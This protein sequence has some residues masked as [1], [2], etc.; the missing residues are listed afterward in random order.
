MENTMKVIGLYMRVSTSKQFHEGY[1]LEGQKEEGTILANRMFGNDIKIETYVD[2]GISG[3]NIQKRPEL[4][5]MM[6]DVRRGKLHAIITFKVSR[7]SRSLSDSLK[8]VELIHNS[9]VRFISIKE[10]EYGT[11]H[12]NLQFNILASVAQYQREELVENVQLGMTQRAK[13]GKWNGG[14]VLG[15]GTA[16]KKELIVIP[17]EADTVQL[18]YHKYVNQG[19]GFKK[20]ATFLNSLG[21]HTKKG[22][23]FT[24]NTVSI[25]LGNPLY[26][27]YIRFNQVI[28]WEKKRRKGKNPDYILVKGIHEP[29]IDEKIWDKAQQISKERASGI[30]RQYS[31]TFPLTKI[32]KCP[33]C[34]SYMTS[35]YGGARRKDGTKKRYY[36]CGQ[37]HNKGKAVCNP[38]TIC[39]DWLEREVFERLTQAL[40]SEAI[41]ADIT[42]RINNQIK[43]HPD[44][45]EQPSDLLILQ[46]RL[47]DL[48]IR[49]NRI[50]ELIESGIYTQ[51]EARD[52][53]INL[54]SEINEA[55]VLLLK[56]Q[57]EHSNNGTLIESVSPDMIRLQIQEFLDFANKLEPLEFRQL[58][59]AT[60]EK[61]EATKSELKH[62]HFSFIAHIQENKKGHDDPSL[63][64][65]SE[66]TSL[67]LRGLP[68][69][70]NQYLLVVR[71]IPIYTKSSIYLLHQN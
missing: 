57:K 51:E 1:S 48:E 59:Q 44:L 40:L 6:N 20:I 18:V 22:K 65:H 5:R 39:A 31:G 35:Q 24:P 13:E 33:E 45:N 62:I 21:I 53:M 4:N 58:L 54:R 8:L 15:Y 42:H 11:P 3:K 16:G 47:S 71:F 38:N 64:T 10:G 23:N 66:Q 19:W 50:Q 55:Q 7:L 25:I 14:Q 36:T 37:Y 43:Q 34:G 61:I 26:K 32:A 27:G 41:I 17:N 68:Y 2:G 29:I 52:R 69:T 46:K 9:N 63:H 28:D 70:K 56:S 60:I 49:K 12:G 30:P 67:L